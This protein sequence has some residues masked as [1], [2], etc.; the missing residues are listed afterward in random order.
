[1]TTSSQ[2]RLT[3]DTPVQYVRGIGPK[4]ASILKNINILTVEDLLTYYPRRY[5]DRSYLT[6]ICDLHQGEDI[7]IVGKVFS[8]EVR[9]GRR[10]RFIL[11][12]GDNTGFLQCVWFQGFS[13]I[14]KAFQVGEV[15]AFSGKV[16]FYRGPQLVHPEYDK[17][18]EVGETNPLHTGRII[19][20]YPSTESLT[21]VGLDS[22]G[23]RRVIRNCLD[24]FSG[25]IDEFLP[26]QIITEE[27]FPNYGDSLENIHFPGDWKLYNQAKKRLKFEELFIIQLYLAKQRD[28]RLNENQGIRFNHVGEQTRQLVKNMPFEFTDAQK[29]VL[30]EIREDMKSSK[31]MNRLL[32]GDVGSGKTIV[33]LVAM[34]IAV[35]NGFQT[36]LMAPTEILA[37]QH[38]VTVH[39]LLQELG[40]R[41]AL[42][43]GGLKKSKSEEIQTK[44]SAGEIDIVIGTHALLQEKIDFNNLGFVVIDE[45]HRFG[46]LQRAKLQY[47]GFHPD[48]LIMTATPIPRTLALTL[49]GDLDTSI[50]D[51]M[52]AGRKPIQTVWR[53]ENKR[54]A[55]YDF[56][57]EELI[58]KRQAYIVYPLIKESE[59]I[60]LAAATEGFQ[61]L[62]RN[63]FQEFNVALLHGR[64]K[65]I[66]K[67]TIMHRFKAGN[68]HVLVS[69][70]VIEVGLDVPNATIMLIE[71][72]ERFGLTQLHQLRGRVGRGS[73]KST[74]ILLS[75]YPITDDAKKRLKTM[76][77]TNDGFRIA[78]A[79]LEIRGPGEL[80]GT[81]QHG[82]LN[83]KIANLITDSKILEKA[84]KEAFQIIQN[85]PKLEK[86]EHRFLKDY[87]HKHGYEKQ[88]LIQIG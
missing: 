17:I 50:I 35:E 68:I 54:E 40:V 58:K 45:Q 55:I 43:T 8:K 15:V 14:Q 77:T 23:F 56:I 46:V 71:H 32:Q 84:R 70:T 6:K 18:S 49:Y 67:E 2:N 31:A 79:D 27:Q 87:Y 39:E 73:E 33:A 9:Q 19:P 7:T 61:E 66:E 21:K 63:I 41:A 52:P 62:S 75:Q 57:R 28:N 12:I 34:L 82:I 3:L 13:Y 20:L 76:T 1:M 36:A 22:R 83:L 42:L 60:D 29:R 4:R 85:D 78:E 72:A 69:T 16:T 37:E 5:L 59:K 10:K 26:K 48:V 80:F 25:R 86:D 11:M 53:G 38:Y 64:M 81:K 65:T 88:D 44:L 47:K 30:R 24:S 51:Q 74:C